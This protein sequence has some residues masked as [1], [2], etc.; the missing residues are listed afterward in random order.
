MSP[1]SHSL[2]SLALYPAISF[3]AGGFIAG[4]VLQ[5]AIIGNTLIDSFL[6][7]FILDLSAS[8]TTLLWIILFSFVGALGFGLFAEHRIRTLSAITAAGISGLI[9]Y[10]ILFHFVFLLAGE[11][12]IGLL[13][14]AVL[15]GYGGY[16]IL[17]FAFGI[18][19]ARLFGI[20]IFLVS[21]TGAFGGVIG[22]YFFAPFG[23]IR[24][25]LSVMIFM[26]AS[27]GFGLGVGTFLSLMF[28]K[29]KQ[30]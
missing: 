15:R 12:L 4:I 22:S 28:S 6:P 25:S 11:S 5:T 17:G 20:R 8:I 10:S 14:L 24:F 13:L 18:V 7:L 21:T 16:A 29:R 27:L 19:V 23:D 9:L 30:E 26:G 1:K 3:A 2:V